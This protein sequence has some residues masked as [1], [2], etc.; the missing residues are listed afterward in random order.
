[1]KPSKGNEA[2]AKNR[3]VPKNE[4]CIP[5]QGARKEN[6][7]FAITAVSVA[8]TVYCIAINVMNVLHTDEKFDSSVDAIFANL[9]AN[10][11]NYYNTR[12]SLEA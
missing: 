10:A 7:M 3:S 6:I 11:E 5:S 9:G 12:Y 8:V 4:K 2:E 1:M